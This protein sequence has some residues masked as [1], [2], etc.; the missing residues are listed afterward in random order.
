MGRP[1]RIICTRCH[2][3]RV[4]LLIGGIVTVLSAVLVGW[5]GFRYAIRQDERRWSRE[6]RAQLYIELLAEASAELDD[7][8]YRLVDRELR[9]MGDEGG[10][11]RAGTDDR[12]GSRDRR[13]LGGRAAAFASREV[14]RRWNR[15]SGLGGRALLARG[16]ETS[17]QPALGMAFDDLEA[18]IRHELEAERLTWYE[19]HKRLASAESSKFLGL[20]GDG[21]L[22]RQPPPQSPQSASTW[23]VTGDES[24]KD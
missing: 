14:I 6:Q 3:E 19:Q 13:L 9:A 10:V 15:F 16:W 20:Y 17:Y 5:L 4:D 18:Q 12:M 8:Q 21:P 7:L 1:A 11:H 23:R 24:R 2:A 22:G